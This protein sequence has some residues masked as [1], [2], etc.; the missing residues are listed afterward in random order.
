MSQ[1]NIA[2]VSEGLAKSVEKSL[3]QEGAAAKQSATVAI[4]IS[5]PEDAAAL[6]FTD[7]H[8]QDAL[9]EISRYLL[10]HGCKLLY[11]G[12]LRMG[13]FTEIFS[14]L[15]KVYTTSYPSASSRAVNYFAWPIHLQLSRAD[16]TE[17]KAN[18]FEIRKLPV[19]Q[20]ANLDAHIYLKPDSLANR[21]IWSKSL[22][23][24]REEMAKAAQA[25]IV[26][27]GRVSHYMGKMPGVLEE[28]LVNV[29][30]EKPLYIAGAFGGSAKAIAEVLQGGE[31]ETLT[32]DF[33]LENTAYKD[34]FLHWNNTE[35]EK[36]SYQVYVEN[37]KAFGL[38]GITQRNGLTEDENRRLFQ[39]PHITEMTQLILKGLNAVGLI[40]QQQEDKTP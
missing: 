2:G 18:G 25:T 3:Q 1:P 16:E 6:G 35:E 7:W 15:A 9:I 36:I 32:E 24:M 39:T 23:S 40:G 21:V 29:K 38:Q 28:I 22:S 19:P 8:L 33:Q 17:F 34:F 20:V 4:S 5:E 37:L 27:G 26:I 12:D 13:G 10:V 30:E 14:E 31:S 11:G